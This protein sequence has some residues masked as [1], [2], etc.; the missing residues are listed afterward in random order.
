MVFWQ[1]GSTAPVRRQV[2]ELHKQGAAHLYMATETFIQNE[3]EIICGE[4]KLG[5]VI[6]RTVASTVYEADPVDAARRDSPAAVI[7][8]RDSEQADIESLAQQWRNAIDLDHANLL[9]ILDAGVC[10]AEG[11]SV[12]YAVMERA[13]ESLVSVLNQRALSR[14]EIKEM[15]DPALRALRYLH[16]KGYVHGALKPSNVFAVGDR[17]KLSSDAARKSSETF[18]IADDMFALGVLLVQA[19]TQKKPEQVDAAA[20]G[21]DSDAEVI[22]R[23]IRHCLDR[24]PARRWTV[25]QIE[26]ALH[27]P[28]PPKPEPRVVEVPRAKVVELPAAKAVQPSPDDIEPE[29]KTGRFPKWAAIALAAIIF[30][31][32]LIAYSRTHEAPAPPPV[33]AVKHDVPPAPTAEPPKPSPLEIPAA[34]AR[35]AA[36]ENT[37]RVQAERPAGRRAQG[38]AVIVAAYGG[39][40]AADKRMN[41]MA[42]KYPKFNISV[43][44][45]NSDRAKFLVVLGQNLSEDEAEALKERAIRSGLPHDTYIKRVM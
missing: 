24:D 42:H 23:I 28:A 36:H 15:L 9:K 7:K 29:H 30:A 8:T 13:D 17:V 35:Q 19:L 33:E 14:D 41:A 34:P 38:W 3:P 5:A 26:N 2:Y 20:Y 10:Q 43:F 27:P 45:Q 12:A 4:Y 18:S 37:P 11:A 31:V 16:D 21:L 40:D 22:A 6:R 25:A 44:E 32:A 39:R 1:Y